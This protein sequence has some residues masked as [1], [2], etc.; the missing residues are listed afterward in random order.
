MIHGSPS[1]Q[2]GQYLTEINGYFNIAE[3]GSLITSSSSNASFLNYCL[4]FFLESSSKRNSENSV[5]QNRQQKSS[6]VG[7]SKNHY[8]DGLKDE[9]NENQL[10]KY[11]SGVVSVPVLKAIMCF[12]SYEDEVSNRRDKAG[13]ITI[14][15]EVGFIYGIAFILSAICIAL[16]ALVSFYICIS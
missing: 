6:N 15:K 9:A 5:T 1:C 10:G 14:P 16:A 2:Y 7:M 13:L 12:A 4:D 11:K 8:S 3:D